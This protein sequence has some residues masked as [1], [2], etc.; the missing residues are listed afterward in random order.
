[1]KREFTATV[2]IRDE[3]RV[4]L[5]Y[6]KKLKKWLPPGGHIDPH[7]LP[8][9]AAI[10]EAREETGLEIELDML[11]SISIKEANAISLPRPF[12]C[13]LEEIP[14]YGDEPA[15]QHIDMVYLA[16]PIG[17]S[18]THNAE[19]TEDIRWFRREEIA[20]L[21]PEVEIFNET[22]QTIEKVLTLC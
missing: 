9:D 15:H 8:C 12:L 1:M 13:L 11:P 3:D 19:E 6:H 14:P 20:E 17:G 5:I 7:E 10:R 2:Y 21:T 22:I 4:L 18:I 16:R